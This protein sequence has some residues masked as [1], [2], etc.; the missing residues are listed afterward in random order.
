MLV[1]LFIHG[2]DPDDVPTIGDYFRSELKYNELVFIGSKKIS[3]KTKQ[4]HSKARIHTVLKEVKRNLIS[5]YPNLEI[6]V[7]GRYRNGEY[8]MY[9]SKDRLDFRDI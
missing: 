3:I 4:P 8:R 9:M 7:I 6:E 5:K 2:V 1:D